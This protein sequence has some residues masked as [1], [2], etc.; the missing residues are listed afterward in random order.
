MYKQPPKKKIVRRLIVIYGVMIALIA[1]LVTLLVFFMLGYRFDGQEQRFEQTGLVQFDSE[2]RGAIVEVNKKR[3]S[4]KT[5]TKTV[6]SQGTH[7]FAMW[8]EGYETWWKQLAIQAGTVT[9]LDYARLIPKERPVESI[10]TFEQL[11]DVSFAPF[12]RFMIALQKPDVPELVL[13]DL[14]DA[15]NTKQTVIKLPETALSGMEE[16][17]VH[18]YEIDEWDQ[19]GRYVLL[20]HSYSDQI[21]WLLLDREKPDELQNVSTIVNLPIVD[22]QLSGSSGNE[23]YI[24][25]EGT[26]RLVK[27]SDGS[28]S[29]A[30]ASRVQQF[31]LYGTG[32]ITYVGTTENNTERVV[33]VVQKDD[34]KPHVLKT[35]T[36]SPDVPV[37]I[38]TSNYYHK[39]Y[40]AISVGSQV[41]I[42]SGDYPTNEKTVD[43]TMKPVTT[44]D[45]VRPIKWLQM[46]GNGR[47]VLAQDD[48]G[49]MS[50]DLERGAQST[51]IDFASPLSQKL[52]WIDSYSVYNVEDGQL[53]LREFDGAN[54]H[55]ILPADSRF[56]S[57]LDQDDTYMYAVAATDKGYALQRV[58]MILQ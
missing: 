30:Y 47:F 35:I 56:A 1:S 10:H 38:T 51:M 48:A 54:R 42:M 53:I 46:S 25:T 7:E 11:E 12:G 18:R 20:K 13:F 3:L 34:Q 17:V 43:Q 41:E 40:I 8:R 9:W 44:F 23:L 31:N 2:P 32:V 5:A 14:R 16:G 37:S 33:G 52:R 45:F 50:Y 21:E 29:R 39:D 28:L 19:G 15:E 49:Y 57:S 4:G 26:I 27:L 22:A 24:L 55:A 36:A 58:R 6:V